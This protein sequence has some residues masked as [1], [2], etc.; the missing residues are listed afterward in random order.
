MVKSSIVVFKKCTQFLALSTLVLYGACSKDKSKKDDDETKLSLAI[1]NSINREKFVEH[2]NKL[3]EIINNT[4]ISLFLKSE[5][6]TADT[7][8]ETAPDTYTLD[9]L[10]SIFETIPE[11]DSE[12][13]PGVVIPN[14]NLD[15]SCSS[16]D[17]T[18]P[19][20]NLTT[21][22][23][24]YNLLTAITSMKGN[25]L[26]GY[27]IELN[28]T[29]ESTDHLFLV[30]LN[31]DEHSV[32][33]SISLVA[34][35]ND[36]ELH[37]KAFFDRHK[38]PND[39]YNTLSH[40]EVELVANISSNSVK[41]TWTGSVFGQSPSGKVDR[42]LTYDN[43]WLINGD[44]NGEI[45]ES[46]QSTDE[47]SSSS[48]NKSGELSLKFINT[49]EIEWQSSEDIGTGEIIKSRLLI[50]NKEE[51][52]IAESLLQQE[53]EPVKVCKVEGYFNSRSSY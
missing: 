3:I 36:D 51:A 50:G 31:T 22:G 15:T 30:K 19:G 5:G 11:Y 21:P 53:T 10:T 9:S 47:L 4:Q 49:D 43:Q 34:G 40:I 13:Y 25:S 28:E 33:D 42:N 27:N 18:V 39:T 14:T 2:A 37:L 7:L 46:F 29:P 8:P 12:A 6:S 45:T 23:I 41:Y 38:H 16:I 48:S 52:A 35:G 32:T 26:F 17:D 24:I 44:G 1:E 20:K